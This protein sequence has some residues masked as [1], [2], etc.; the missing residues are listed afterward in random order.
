MLDM[1]SGEKVQNLCHVYIG[2]QEDFYYNP[3]ISRQPEK[4]LDIGHIPPLWNNPSLIFCYSHR[5][6]DFSRK[7]VSIQN[8]CVIVFGN[9]DENITYEVSKPFLESSCVKHIVCQNIQFAHPKASFLPIGIANA[10]W[11]HGNM[12]NFNHITKEKTQEVFCNFSVSTNPTVRGRCVESM[13][14]HGILQ[15]SGFSQDTYIQHLANHRYS[16]CPEGNGLDTHRFWESLYVQT[17]PIATRSS[18]TEQ[19]KASGLPCILIE[20]WETFSRECLEEYSDYRFDDTYY[21][22]LSFATL[23]NY[24]LSKLD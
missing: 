19:I 17:I 16:I 6:L 1:I 11:P 7:V 20:S 10:M 2:C 15:T 13:N 18:L 22:R 24:I 21:E 8:P 3:Q 4:H 23:Q 9:S 12:G 5:I 14:K